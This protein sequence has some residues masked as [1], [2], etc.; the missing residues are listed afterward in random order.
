[1]MDISSK[2]LDRGHMLSYFWSTSKETWKNV[3]RYVISEIKICDQYDVLEVPAPIHSYLRSGYSF[4]E[5][6]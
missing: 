5:H 4:S 2:L 6:Q 1:M 3:W